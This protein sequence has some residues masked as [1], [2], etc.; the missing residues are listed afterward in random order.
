MSINT[1]RQ[2]MRVRLMFLNQATRSLTQDRD[3]LWEK[4]CQEFLTEIRQHVESPNLIG[5][6]HNGKVYPPSAN[7][8]KR[9][10][11]LRGS[12]SIPEVFEEPFEQ[13]VKFYEDE[14]EPL[15]AE[16]LN[17]LRKLTQVCQNMGELL[18]ALPEAIHS[19][20]DDTYFT[21]LDNAPGL[22][23]QEAKDMILKHKSML[24]RM[25]K[26]ISLQV[27]L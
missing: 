18:N 2:K 3:K 17:Y 1:Q 11:L 22:T 24:S 26:Y 16:F 10:A 5:F 23:K 20:F 25:A 9:M 19:A 4:I 13:K 12:I 21:P 15:L 14:W 6:R 7:S 27:L 8:M